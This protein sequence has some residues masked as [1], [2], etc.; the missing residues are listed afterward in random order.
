VSSTFLFSIVAAVSVMVS[1]KTFGGGTRSI[2]KTSESLAG[3]SHDD[4]LSFR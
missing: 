4:I 2:P 1:S 3:L